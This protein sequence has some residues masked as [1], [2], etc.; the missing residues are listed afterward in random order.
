M[1]EEASGMTAQEYLGQVKTKEAVIKNLERDRAN[2]LAMMYSLG[3]N[4]NGERVQSSKDPDKFGTLYGK[5]DE[6]ERKIADEIDK[7]VDFKLKV[8]GEINEIEDGRYVEL[9]HKR[10]IQNET[11][12]TISIDMQYSRKYILQLHGSALKEF[13]SKFN[14]MLS[15]SYQI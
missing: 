14:D 6:K 3:G 4:G 13:Q 12:D 9:L 5:I 8:S 2:L 11:W 1:Q 7:L 15:E 10:Y